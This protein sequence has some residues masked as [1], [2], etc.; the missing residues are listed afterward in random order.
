MSSM[1]RASH[2]V[3][4]KHACPGVRHSSSDELGHHCRPAQVSDC[5]SAKDE[6]QKKWY[7]WAAAASASSE[8]ADPTARTMAMGRKRRR[9]VDAA[10]ND[11][12][13][14][15]DH[16]DAPPPLLPPPL[17][18]EFLQVGFIG[19]LLVIMVLLGS[20]KRKK[21]VSNISELCYDTVSY[22]I[23]LS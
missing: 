10:G 15:D 9:T 8:V 4:A 6:P 21:K 18:L 5:M 16:D 12:G 13:G 1:R 22:H 7:L 19:M 17:L 3:F 20:W 2:G 23:V 14:G 11:A